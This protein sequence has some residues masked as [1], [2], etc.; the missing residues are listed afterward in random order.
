MSAPLRRAPC[1]APGRTAANRRRSGLLP[2]L[3]PL[4]GPRVAAHHA[5]AH[6]HL[7]AAGIA[8]GFADH[9]HRHLRGGGL[10]R[11]GLR[12][13]FIG[14]RARL[15]LFA[16]LLIVR[17]ARTVAFALGGLL[18]LPHPLGHVVERGLEIVGRAAFALLGERLGDRNSSACHLRA[19]AWHSSSSR[20]A[21]SAA[22]DPSWRAS[23]SAL[24]AWRARP[25]RRSS[26][27]RHRRGGP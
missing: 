7:G 9:L 27:P 19:R 21:S 3:P 26:R 5:A 6:H 17:V 1:E 12:L 24:R 22:P 18:A 11:R 20:P 4:P 23:P 15:A 14:R 8:G 13:R 16:G 25:R 10:L 2:L